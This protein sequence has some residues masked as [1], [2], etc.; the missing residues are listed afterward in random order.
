MSW[1]G[2]IIKSIFNNEGIGSQQNP[3]EEK[4]TS[5][6]SESAVKSFTLKTMSKKQLEEHGRTL[7]IELDRR[8]TKAKLIAQ[9]TA[10]Q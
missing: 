4:L 6:K 10:A 7:G 9:I 2:N 3:S 1:L 8:K 5:K